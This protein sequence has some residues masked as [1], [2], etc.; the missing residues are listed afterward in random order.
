MGSMLGRREK[1]HEDRKK[2]CTRET[3]RRRMIM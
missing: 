2:E 1:K 3:N